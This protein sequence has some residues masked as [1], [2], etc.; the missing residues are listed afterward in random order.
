MELLALDGWAL[1]QGRENGDLPSLQA[2]CLHVHL[3]EFN[4][5]HNYEKSVWV[6]AGLQMRALRPREVKQHSCGHTASESSVRLSSDLSSSFTTQ[7]TCDFL[8]G[9]TA[10]DL[11]TDFAC[12]PQ[13]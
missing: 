4:S 11:G 5:H 6:I 7:S 2:L 10:Q 13:R 12:K 9:A 1:G 3:L 8:G